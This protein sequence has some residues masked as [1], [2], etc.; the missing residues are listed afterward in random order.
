M[1]QRSVYSDNETL[2]KKA[3]KKPN[4]FLENQGERTTIMSKKAKKIKKFRLSGIVLFCV[5]LLGTLMIV[6]ADAQAGRGRRSR[7]GWSS[8]RHHRNNFRRNHRRNRRWR[9]HRRYNNSWS[10]FGW[11]AASIANSFAK[12]RSRT[13]YVVQQP[14]GCYDSDYDSWYYYEGPTRTTSRREVIIVP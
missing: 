8:K 10:D 6:P 14:Q 3:L 13:V 4:R 12:S 1:R 2:A 11:A 9:N 7:R 5:I